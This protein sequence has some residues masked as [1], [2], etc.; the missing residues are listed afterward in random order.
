MR[1][2]AAQR[3]LVHG[4]PQRRRQ[5]RRDVRQRHPRLRGLP[6]PRGARDRRRVRDR[7]PRRPQAGPLRGTASSRSTSATG[8]SA[9]P[10]TPRA[11]GFDALVKVAGHDALL[12]AAASTSATRTPWSR[13][14]TRPTSPGSTSPGAAR[15]TRSRRTAPTSSSS[16][17]SATGTC[18][19]GCTSA[20][21]ARP[22]PAAPGAAAAALAT[23]WWAGE[24]STPTYWRV[25]VPG[26][27]PARAG[28]AR[29][30]GRAG[31]PGRP[32]RRRHHGPRLSAARLSRGGGRGPGRT[33]PV[34]GHPPSRLRRTVVAGLAVSGLAVRSPL[35]GPAA[36][37]GPVQRRATARP[38]PAAPPQRPAAAQGAGD[39]RQR[40]RRRLRR[41]GRQ[42]GRHR[43]PAAGGNAADAA[44]A[45]AA[46]LGVTEPFSSGIGGGGFLVYYDARTAPGRARSTA[47]RPRP[48]RS[49]RTTFT[50]GRRHRVDFNTVVSSGLS[51]GVP[52]TPALW[53][54]AARRFGTPAPAPTCSQP[55]AAARQPRASSSTRPSTSRPPHNADAVRQVPRDGQGL[56]ARRQAARRSARCSATPT[57]PRPTPSCARKG[58]DA[59]LPRASSARTLVARRAHPHDRRRASA[60]CRAAHRARDLAATAALDKGPVHSTLPGPGR[61]R[62]AG[63]RPPAASPSARSST[64]SRPTTQ[65]TGTQTSEVEQRPSTCTASARPPPP[66]SPTATARSATCPACPV[67][68]AAPAGLRRRAGLPLRPG[69]GAA[70]ADPVRHRPTAAT[71]TARRARRQDQPREGPSTTHLT[72]GRPVGQ[73]RV[74]HADHRADRRLRDHR[75]RLGLPAQQRADRLQL[76]AA[77]RGRAG[78]EPA[79]PRQAAALVDEPDDR[80]QGRPPVAR[81]RLARRRHDHHHGAQIAARLPRPRPVP[82]RRDRRAAAVLAQRQGRGR[83]AGDRRRA[84]RD[85]AEGPGP[86]AGR[87]PGDRCGHGNPG[88]R[89]REVQAAA[90]PTR[91]GGGSAMVVRPDGRQP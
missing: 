47:A 7:H 25:D 46:A 87:H 20:A 33:V 23:R 8:G 34:H 86:H 19:C 18:A 42:P 51:V 73:R 15:S 70:A 59:A 50:D 52:G 27:T 36:A 81:P 28:A 24:P 9:T 29:P 3:A 57:W 85:G 90:E 6:A 66:R 79:R 10:T 1:A 2:Q 60:S 82:G 55:A 56:P 31:R 61:L 4:L 43:R 76:R 49:P 54:V 40:R 64:S 69:H 67:R 38:R 83:R 78:P 26:G 80:A 5:R 48:G 84:R 88:A 65:R 75:A 62:H 89:P 53:D 17:R 11:D 32:G 72:V 39:D 21:S 44:V 12:G 77:D 14:P 13:C 68:R 58:V 22:A 35:A 30:A 16:G 91:R 41:P 74:V 37:S 71:P 45:T 63:A